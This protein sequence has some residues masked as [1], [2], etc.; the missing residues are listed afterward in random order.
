MNAIKGSDCG[1]CKGNKDFNQR[2]PEGLASSGEGFDPGNVDIDPYVGDVS[3]IPRRTGLYTMWLILSQASSGRAASAGLSVTHDQLVVKRWEFEVRGKS[4]FAIT[5]IQRL[6]S[7]KTSGTDMIWD[8]A[9]KLSTACVLKCSS[10]AINYVDVN[11]GT[12]V[13]IL[14]YNTSEGS[15]T[16]EHAS[17]QGDGR[18]GIRFTLRHAPAGFFVNPVN[19]EVLGYPSTQDIAKN[20]NA[21]EM[22]T[23]LIAVEESGDE[24]IIERF[25]FNVRP[26]RQFSPIF[27]NSTKPNTTAAMTA[28]YI[29]QYID[30]TDKNLEYIVGESYRIAAKTLVEDSTLV[31]AGGMEDIYFSLSIGAPRL[32][33]VNSATGEIVGQVR[34]SLSQLTA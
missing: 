28:D 18:E 32:F 16:F 5:S 10:A 31:S 24:F 23:Q 25:A 27:I 13:S 8:Q 22:V 29:D 12:R 14:G 15:F 34:A 3:A 17:G 21:N 2:P 20:A 30:P 7:S 33:F 9:P 1:T 19:G 11:V 6:Q 26:M 4:P